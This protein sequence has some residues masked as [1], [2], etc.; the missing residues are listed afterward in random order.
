M[1]EAL[2]E[3]ELVAKHFTGEEIDDFL[4]PH[5]YTGLSSKFVDRVLNSRKNKL[6]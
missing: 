6:L 5:K 2:L 4:E 3:N 1:K